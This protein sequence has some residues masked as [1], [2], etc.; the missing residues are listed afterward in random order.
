[1]IAAVS[2]IEAFTEIRVG[3][4]IIL[5][6]AMVYLIYKMRVDSK[7]HNE[8]FMVRERIIENK[9]SKFGIHQ[10]DMDKEFNDTKE[11]MRMDGEI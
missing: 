9:L 2:N 4:I 1:L 3:V 5:A 6:T 7:N 11:K 8:H 10:K